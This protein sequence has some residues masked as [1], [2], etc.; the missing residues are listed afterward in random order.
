ML[1]TRLLSGLLLA[2]LVTVPP[3]HARAQ[4][5]VRESVLTGRNNVQRTGVYDQEVVLTPTNVASGLFRR[6]VARPVRGQ[7][8]AQPLY[9]RGV[10]INGVR[11]NAVY[12]VT[13]LNY[14]YAFD[15]DN[16]NPDDPRE[17]QLWANPIHLAD[18]DPPA[19]SNCLSNPQR[20]GLDATPLRGMDRTGKNDKEGMAGNPGC[21]Q[22]LGPV[23][24]TSAP[25][26][27]PVLQQMFLVARFGAPATSSEYGKQV[28]YYLVSL[29]I[30]TGQEIRRMRIGDSNGSFHANA[31]LNRP[32][33]LLL[34]NVVYVAFGAPV[35]DVG[36]DGTND[37]THGWV[38][39]YSVPD[40][41]Y[42]DA[43]NTSP[44]SHLASIWQ[45]GAGLAADP[46]HNLVYALTGNN[47]I[48]PANPVPGLGES[49][50]QF[51]LDGR[52][53]LNLAAHFTAGNWYRLDTG[54]HCPAEITNPIGCR[55][56]SKPETKLWRDPISNNRP[57]NDSDL[58]SGGPVV[59]SN[60]FVLGGGKQ[61]RLY[62][63]DGR[64][65][66]FHQSQPAF[67]APINSWH[68]GS[69]TTCTES[70]VRGVKCAISQEDYDVGQSWGP[71]IHGSPVVWE[72]PGKSNGF[73]YIMA[74]KDYL[75]AYP[76]MANGH[77][78]E[79]PAWT[80]EPVVA[81]SVFADKATPAF[82]NGKFMSPDGMPGGAVSVSSNGDSGGIVWVSVAP[83][84]D[85]TYTMEPGML[86]AFDAEK[87]N[88]LWYDP[89]YT[90]QF[91]KFVPP[92]IAGGKVF[93]ATYGER[94]SP[95]PGIG[96][97][98]NHCPV[99]KP[100]KYEVQDSCGSLV[101]YGYRPGDRVM[102]RKHFIK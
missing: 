27:D 29:D 9:V 19:P 37:H 58:G 25:V 3:F 24:I 95:I 94:S 102:Q 44:T 66:N 83:N 99:G 71:N 16:I 97:G 68:L 73:L 61:G 20:L 93:L 101:I 78:G 26:I 5:S 46:A 13:R 53:R 91:A 39:A 35:C 81:P 45:S 10:T 12:V 11:K 17:G 96:L 70:D 62:A 80:S 14:I 4:I 50:L 69:P 57:E 89:D 2:A 60:G 6:L 67:Q 64:S 82:T 84:Q 90:H 75:R 56:A 22:T 76:V 51:N 88:L 21:G 28:Y 47:D 8:A 34:N 59:Q 38:F 86:A 30:R 32:A 72:R 52:R 41:T 77:V 55:D 1:Y 42:L 7:V 100:A 15:A 85:A 54:F 36:E 48:A 40:M 79:T 98:M 49:I 63:I 65:N 18:C 43:Y 33:L 74:E 87:G 23:G 92:M 31:E